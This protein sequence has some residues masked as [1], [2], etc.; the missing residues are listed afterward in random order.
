MAI[1]AGLTTSF[2]LELLQG[3]HDLRTD[4]LKVALY[5]AS[6]SLGPET[7][8]YTTT[9]EASGTGY[10]AGGSAL[11]VT[12]PATSGTT[13]YADFANVTWSTASFT[14]RG[15]LIYNSSQGNRAI[16]VLDFGHNIAKVA[17]DFVLTFPPPTSTEA[18]IRLS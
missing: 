17:A 16:A 9:G 10:S 6:A 14:A 18:I 13:A 8:S 2:K 3:I 1:I 11:T 15:A 7:T 5:T 12:A 4:T